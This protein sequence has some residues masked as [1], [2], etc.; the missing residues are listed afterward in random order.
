MISV[1]M[2]RI[3][4]PIERLETRQLLAADL[5]YTF[6]AAGKVKV[7]LGEAG[8]RV[9]ATAL[10]PDGKILLAGDRAG[11]TDAFV[12][13]LNADDSRDAPFG[14]SGAGR[15][16]VPA[17]STLATFDGV[18]VDVAAD[19]TIALLGS[20]VPE[21]YAAERDAYGYTGN[22]DCVVLLDAKGALVNSFDK[23]GVRFL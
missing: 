4:Q 6:G 7:D 16:D 19:G 15:V 22:T 11:S 18:G 10:Q 2:G 5:D 23:N 1:R 3:H 21:D 8:V 13:R 9:F 20:A 17:D 12:A 14:A